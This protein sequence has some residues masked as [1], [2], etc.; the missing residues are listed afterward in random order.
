MNCQKI[1][2]G[3]TPRYLKKGGK[4]LCKSCLRDLRERRSE[5]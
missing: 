1:R 5:A 4:A 2:G 3:G